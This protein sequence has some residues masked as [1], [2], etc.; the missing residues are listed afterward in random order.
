M[1]TV[2]FMYC[3][4]CIYLEQCSAVIYSVSLYT[5]IVSVV[6]CSVSV[7]CVDL[8][9]CQQFLDKTSSHILVQHTYE[10]PCSVDLSLHWLVH[11]SIA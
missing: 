9:Q 6:Y 2:L 11:L 4:C 10:C 5:F 1:L 7:F 8:L 3:K